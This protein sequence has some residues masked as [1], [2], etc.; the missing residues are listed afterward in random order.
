MDREMQALHLF[1]ITSAT[2]SNYTFTGDVLFVCVLTTW[3][4]Q[5]TIG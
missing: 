1:L 3:V 5:D 2:S 4:I